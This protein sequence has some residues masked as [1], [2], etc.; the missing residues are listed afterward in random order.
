MIDN[1]QLNQP[2]KTPDETSAAHAPLPIGVELQVNIYLTS[3]SAGLDLKLS[4][5]GLPY[6]PDIP[7]TPDA[8][9]LAAALG[10]DVPDDANDWRLMTVDEIRQYKKD[11]N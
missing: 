9:R 11:E 3:D 5:A 4:V 6:M 8:R 1:N 7:A 10:R 2:Q